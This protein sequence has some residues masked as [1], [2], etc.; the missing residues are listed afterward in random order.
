MSVLKSATQIAKS[1]K[2]IFSI[3]VVVLLF[4]IFL[5]AVYI[6]DPNKNEPSALDI[7]KKNA[8]TTD[9]SF[10]INPSGNVD[11]EANWRERSAADLQQNAAELA[12]TK[13]QL[14]QLKQEL[15][16]QKQNQSL[17]SNVAPLAKPEPEPSLPPPSKKSNFNPTLPPPP[18]QTAIGGQALAQQ[19]E[20]LNGQSAFAPS[21]S[22]DNSGVV[23][24]GRIKKL[25][26]KS[27]DSVE[28]TSSEGGESTEVKRTVRNVKTYVPAGAFGRITL[29][30]GVDAPT[31]GLADSNPMP[32]LMKIRDK[33]TLANYFK[34]D[35]KECTVIGAAKGNLSS[36]RVEIRLETITCILANGTV[37]EEPIKGYVAGEDGKAGFRGKVISKQG[38]IIA[39]AAM[40]GVAGGMG[41]AVQEQYQ[42]VS[43]SALGTV[44]SIDPNKVF[45]SGAAQGFGSAMDKIAEF[46]ISRAN[47]T[48][49]IVELASAR[50]G[51]LVLTQGVDFKIPHINLK[52]GN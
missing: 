15:E 43:S 34:T 30:S 24:T 20:Y 37:I 48:Y 41:R 38:S 14:D 32:V 52:R 17:S 21:T 11:S 19:A 1:K 29:L 28:N 44:T 2:A 33:G 12:A 49:P 18:S 22:P 23:R 9:K 42:T 47:E 27:S 25:S 3:I 13:A 26:A 45:Q 46:Y 31:G 4:C 39:K 7:A 51:D 40:A 6:S 5:L 16:L 50:Q 35:L 10:D 8:A 36:E